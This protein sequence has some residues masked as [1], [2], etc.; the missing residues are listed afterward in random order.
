VRRLEGRRIHGS[1]AGRRGPRT[2][3]KGQRAPDIREGEQR[4]RACDN[5]ARRVR[6]HG[7]RRQEVAGGGRRPGGARALALGHEGATSRCRAGG[8]SRRRDVQWACRPG[9]A[10]GEEPPREERMARICAAPDGGSWEEAAG[11]RRLPAGK[12]AP[13][14]WAEPGKGDPAAPPCA[15]GEGQL[16]CRASGRGGAPGR[17]RG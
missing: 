11:R 10:T 9:T 15:G 14:P 2:R 6:R 3:R 12:S 13:T 4:G 1:D 7:W 5:G 17:R 16:P 8:S